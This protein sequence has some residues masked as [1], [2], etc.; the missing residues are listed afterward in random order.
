MLGPE[1]HD[2]KEIDILNRVV[3][4]QPGELRYEA[5]PRHVEKMLR[6]MG[7]EDCNVGVVPGT[8][9]DGKP[10]DDGD[11][12][13]DRETK[14]VFRSVVA[15]A[16]YLAADRADIRFSVKE[17]CRRMSGPTKSDWQALKKLCRYVKGRP[18]VVQVVKVGSE[19]GEVI[20]VYVDSDYAGCR[21]TRRSTSGGCIMWGGACLKQWSSTQKVV[22]LSSGEA[23]YYAALKGAGEGLGL[24]SMLLD[25]GVHIK[26]VLHTDANACKG[27]CGRQGLG[28]LRHMEVAYL[29]LQD[30]VKEKRVKMKKVSGKSNPADHLTKFLTRRELDEAM[31]MLGMQ[32]QEH[33]S[34]IID[35]I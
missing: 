8:K 7:M 12:E 16:N 17:L 25:V 4:W 14:R 32:D 31:V 11:E 23:E 20:D 6:D 33:R 22:A 29:W 10:G 2:A 1:G 21:R 13:L 5:D 18:R 19:V 35:G 3:V 9:F 34:S 26:V 27:I 24:Q 30:V 15:R 28:K